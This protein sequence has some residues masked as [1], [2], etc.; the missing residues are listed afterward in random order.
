MLKSPT[1]PRTT[2]P[3]KAMERIAVEFYLPGEL[4]ASLHGKLAVTQ[5]ARERAILGFLRDGDISRGKAGE[6][7]GLNVHEMLDLM[8]REDVPYFD[9]TKE[10]FDAG[11][12]VA[13]SIVATRHS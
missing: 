8:N 6:L 11:L 7:L 12:E 10:E 4:V 5:R 9:C 3:P 13:R 2:R 1:K